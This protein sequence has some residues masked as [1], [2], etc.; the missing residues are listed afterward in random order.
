MRAHKHSWVCQWQAA[1]SARGTRRERGS[2]VCA[3]P[4][5]S[6][7]GSPEPCTS[8]GSSNRQQWRHSCNSDTLSRETKRDGV[9]LLLID[10]LKERGSGWTRG[11]RA[12]RVRDQKRETRTET[13][14]PSSDTAERARAEEL[15]RGLC[16]VRTSTRVFLRGCVLHFPQQRGDLTDTDEHL[17][18]SPIMVIHPLISS[19]KAN[20]DPH[21]YIHLLFFWSLT[22]P[23]NDY[24]WG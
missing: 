3:S 11:W 24:Q 5:A 9:W 13:A 18:N 6:E 22:Q 14:A 23:A 8:L 17:T 12:H 16:N 4:R 7:L 2:S 10:L 1:P 21:I 20:A 15:A 19:A